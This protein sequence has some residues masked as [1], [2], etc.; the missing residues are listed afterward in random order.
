MIIPYH[1]FPNVYEVLSSCSIYLIVCLF[2]YFMNTVQMQTKETYKA[3]GANYILTSKFSSYVIDTII[4]WCVHEWRNYNNILHMFPN[5]LCCGY[6]LYGSL[7][8]QLTIWYDV[9]KVFWHIFFLF[10]TVFSGLHWYVQWFLTLHALKADHAINYL[11][12]L[13]FI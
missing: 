7:L 6:I 13:G 4:N 10:L 5:N 1:Y 11:T 2:S 8:F 3:N 12:L 9:S